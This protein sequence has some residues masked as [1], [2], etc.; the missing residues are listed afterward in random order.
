MCATASL[1]FDDGFAL[2]NRRDTM[3]GRIIT[4]FFFV[5]GV[6]G[7]NRLKLPQKQTPAKENPRGKR[8]PEAH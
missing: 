2:V 1:P 4:V 8:F 7:A 6:G 3:S 5:V